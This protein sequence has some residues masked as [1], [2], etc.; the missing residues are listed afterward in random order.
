LSLDE[1][2]KILQ[3][4]QFKRTK[5]RETILEFFSS[6]DRY[7]TALEVRNHLE[8]DNPGISFDTIYRN[9]ATFVELNILEE[10]DLNG[11]RNFRMQ[12]DAGVHHH[13][14]ICTRCGKTKNISHCPMEM[15]AVNLPNY[16]IEG[17]KF[18]IYG[19][20]PECIK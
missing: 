4:S 16:K 18:E 12:C 20:C 17:H 8:P 15:I 2:W 10:T 3:G 11:E 6:N 13:H 1:A 7:L 5:N 9:L 14:F 19:K